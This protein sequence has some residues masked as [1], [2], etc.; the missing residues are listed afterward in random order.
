[1]DAATIFSSQSLR[2]LVRPR[3]IRDFPKGNPGPGRKCL[4]N[5]NILLNSELTTPLPAGNIFSGLDS[6]LV[7][8][9]KRSSRYKGNRKVL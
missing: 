2:V 4:S 7:P 5:E 9:R 6:A 3:Q 8:A 1:M